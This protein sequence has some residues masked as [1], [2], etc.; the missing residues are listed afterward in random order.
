MVGI[1]AGV[2]LI[3]TVL[4]VMNGF[5]RTWRD[6]IIGNRAHFTVQSG[7]GPIEDYH[8]RA[9]RRRRRCRAWSAASP[10]VDAEGMVRGERGEIMAVRVRGVDPDARRPRDRPA[11]R[12]A[13][14]APRGACA[15]EA[16]QGDEPAILIG[17]QLAASLGAARRRSAAC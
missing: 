5:E 15:P 13:S 7:L 14:R 3:I 1:A 6:E 8:E 12:P 11:R 4:S 2:W 16:Q 10:F 9:R 17:S